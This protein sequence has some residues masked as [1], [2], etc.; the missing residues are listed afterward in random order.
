MSSPR[1]EGG[2]EIKGTRSPNFA[3]RLRKACD[4]NEECPPLHHGRLVWLQERLTEGGVKISVESAR[5]WLD[6]EGRPRQD[7]CEQ[8]ARILE[9]DASWLYMGRKGARSKERDASPS[10]SRAPVLP[11]AIRDGVVV[12]ISGLPLDLNAQEASKIANVVLAH[13]VPE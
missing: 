5:K 11:I 1:K 13:A 8:L 12:E 10:P 7:K 9:V 2:M 6:G 4:D 3:R